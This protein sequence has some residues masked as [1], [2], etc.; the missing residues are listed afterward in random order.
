[1]ERRSRNVA[2]PLS[3]VRDWAQCA[4]Q[5]PVSELYELVE[6]WAELRPLSPVPA[7]LPELVEVRAE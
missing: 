4:P 2:V 7:R 3:L 1:M 5:R 6:E